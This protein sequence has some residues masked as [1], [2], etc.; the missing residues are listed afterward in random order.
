M[1]GSSAR[2][3]IEINTGWGNDVLT[4]EDGYFDIY[5]SSGTDTLIVNR[6]LSEVKLGA[7]VAGF[8]VTHPGG[9]AI[10]SNV[11][12]LQLTDI[13]YNVING[14]ITLPSTLTGT[15]GND[16]MITRTYDDTLSGG[17][18]DDWLV[19]QWGDDVMH[20]GNGNDRIY[21]GRDNDTVYGDAG[22]D[23]LSGETGEDKI[24]GGAG[25]DVISGGKQNDS[26]WGDTGNDRLSGNSGRDVLYGGSGNDVLLGGGGIDL[27]YGQ[28]GN[29]RIK[30]GVGYDSLSGGQGRDVLMGGAGLDVL[31]GQQGRDRLTGG[32]G[33]DIFR[34]RKGHG[35][36]IVTD[37][38]VGV[39]HLQIIG[40]P[41][42]IGRLTFEAEGADTRVSF[43]KLEILVEDVTVAELRD[44]DHFQLL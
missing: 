28:G 32:E 39:D 29:D 19:S 31:E 5:T 2:T 14:K 21:A 35:Q 22:H 18:G 10:V 9:A 36:D 24:Y 4:L 43:G 38:E 1:S 12:I 41:N 30:G 26:V 25:D 16:L 33:A 40:G 42:R 34:F 8:G 27:L 6:L 13:T 17:D 20:G 15:A 44:A 23:F 11:E 7:S 37:F 3:W